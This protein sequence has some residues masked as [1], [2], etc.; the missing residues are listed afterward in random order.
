MP[1]P[2]VEPV[3]ERVIEHATSRK[4]RGRARPRL[5][6]NLVS[7]IDVTFLLLVYFMVATDFRLGEE[8]YR[9]DLPARTGAA[10]VDPFDL[11]DEPLR[12]RVASIGASLATYRL[13]LDGPYRQVKTFDELHDFLRERAMD[14][15]NAG[16]LFPLDHPIVIEPTTT[17]HWQHAMA[18]FDAAARARYTNITFGSAG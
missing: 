12:I 1:Q 5:S 13:Q 17:T 16:G 7:M 14:G 9:L 15:I 11:D 6:L 10:E 18:V 4:R 8:V 2:I 3:E